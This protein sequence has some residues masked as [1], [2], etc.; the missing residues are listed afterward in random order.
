MRIEGREVKAL[1]FKDTNVLYVELLLK[2]G[3]CPEKREFPDVQM[4]PGDCQGTYL[5]VAIRGDK[6][7]IIGSIFSEPHIMYNR[8]FLEKHNLK[9]EE[10]GKYVENYMKDNRF[11]LESYMGGRKKRIYIG[12]EHVE[13]I[14]EG[15]VF[16]LAQGEFYSLLERLRQKDIEK[17]AQNLDNIRRIQIPTTTHEFAKF[18]LN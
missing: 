15:C 18:T 7:R 9:K 5:S 6:I 17:I 16:R 3:D 4:C 1:Y 14:F 12:G 13:T 2:K 10:I 8:E 11:T